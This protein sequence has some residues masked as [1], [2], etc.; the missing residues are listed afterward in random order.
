MG[1]WEILAFGFAAILV[2]GALIS[3]GSAIY[4][5]HVL[6][7]WRRDPTSVPMDVVC[8][9]ID[10]EDTSVGLLV[11]CG[12]L[13]GGIIGLPFIFSRHG[14]ELI[15]FLALAGVVAGFVVKMPF[16]FLFGPRHPRA[17]VDS[18]PPNGGGR[19]PYQ[20]AA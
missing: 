16:D 2:G 12:G 19:L 11:G 14:R 8:K 17:P 18:L 5:E 15:G 9:H 1:I 4:S 10:R 6:E 20:H 7:R 3:I 13:V